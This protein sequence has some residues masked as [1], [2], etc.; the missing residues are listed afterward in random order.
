MAF[1]A[2]CAAIT[3]FRGRGEVERRRCFGGGESGSEVGLALDVEL[4]KRF[5]SKLC[6]VSNNHLS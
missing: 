1:A 6:I 2:G 4:S 5:K 3:F